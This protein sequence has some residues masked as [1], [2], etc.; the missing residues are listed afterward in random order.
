LWDS[1]EKTDPKHVKKITG[2]AYQGN[3]P[4]PH[5]L[6]WKATEAFG[7]C[8]IGWGYQVL[9]LTVEDGGD[10]GKLS[11]ARVS[12]WYKTKD[13]QLASLEH[14][15]GTPFSGHRRDG[16]PFLDEDA[17]KKSVTDA[18]VKAMSMVGFAGDIF[19]GRYDDSKYVN[20]ITQEFE[21]GRNS[22][23]EAEQERLVQAALDAFIDA[24]TTSALVKVWKES[25]VANKADFT[26]E[27][28][29]RLKEAYVVRGTSLRDKEQKDGGNG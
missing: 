6:V 12:F 18:L 10:A 13:G 19:M 7:P 24:K 3:S 28:T 9:S 26:S 15:G 29:A 14:V 2:K 5:Y 17:P 25:I 8:G 21:Q 1:L 4:K 11:V 20:E 16:T 22:K 27:S 23:A